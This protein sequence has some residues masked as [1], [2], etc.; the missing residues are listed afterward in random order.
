[1][2]DSTSGW[3]IWGDP[4]S[5]RRTP[6][7]TNEGQRT[8]AAAS[9]LWWMCNAYRIPEH[10][11]AAM[12]TLSS[13]FFVLYLD[14]RYKQGNIKRGNTICIGMWTFPH[15]TPLEFS[16]ELT[17]IPAHCRGGSVL[18]WW[19]EGSEKCWAS[20]H[21]PGVRGSLWNRPAWLQKPNKLK[22]TSW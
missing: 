3:V 10:L 5:S 14:F 8:A 7:C 1:M 6:I 9:S 2:S 19:G 11:D 12:G 22:I 21:S 16:P 13:E 4:E 15:K 17:V 20:I 18:L